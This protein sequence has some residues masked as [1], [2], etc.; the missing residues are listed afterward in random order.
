MGYSLAIGPTLVQFPQPGTA[1]ARTT[2]QAPLVEEIL[3]TARVIRPDDN[4]A[5]AQSHAKRRD[6][7]DLTSNSS[8]PDRPRA[9]PFHGG[10]EAPSLALGELSAAGASAAFVAQLLG[11]AGAPGQASSL[12]H[13][14]D[15]AEIT[16]TAYRQ[17]GGEPALF[18]SGAALV[19]LAV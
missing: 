12:R 9:L 2:R 8:D 16:S 13:H 19:R 3:G 14:R 5:K 18:S 11:Q 7:G 17:A 1:V 4:A 6:G 15:G 10:P